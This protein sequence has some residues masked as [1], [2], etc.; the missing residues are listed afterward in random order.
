MTAHATRSAIPLVV[1]LLFGA[2]AQG[3]PPT[4]LAAAAR[5]G[6]LADIDRLIATG[7]D[8]NE[9]SGRNNWPPLIHAIHKGRRQ[10]VMRLLEHGASLDGNVGR[11]A[12]FMA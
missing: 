7:A 3:A 6:D 11:T 2:C 10:A 5:R 9:P 12:L 4:P 8:V 1:I